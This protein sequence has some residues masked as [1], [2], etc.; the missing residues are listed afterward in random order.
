MCGACGET[1]LFPSR[2]HHYAERFHGQ[3]TQQTE[4]FTFLLLAACDVFDYFIHRPNKSLEPCSSARDRLKS[5]LQ[6]LTPES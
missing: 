3:V 6:K 5:T 2:T 1:E 4:V